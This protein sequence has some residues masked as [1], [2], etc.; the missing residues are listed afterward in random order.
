MD[1][2]GSLS[3]E[4]FKDAYKHDQQ[5]TDERLKVLESDVKGLEK[6]VDP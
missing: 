3:F 6:R 4:H 1:S 2:V 5:R